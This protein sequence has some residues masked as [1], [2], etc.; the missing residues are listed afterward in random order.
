MAIL[1][2]G[3]TVKF[4]YA[5]WLQGQDEDVLAIASVQ[6]ANQD[7]YKLVK[8]VLDLNDGP[9]IDRIALELS[10]NFPIS[11]VIAHSEYDLL[12]AARLRE[13]LGL[14]G[15]TV[16]GAIAYRDKVVMK[17][18]LERA[19]IAVAHADRL[20]EPL[21]AI[22]FVSKHGY[23]VVLKPTDGAGSHDVVIAKSESEVWDALTMLRPGAS[24]IETYVEGTMYH[25]NG[26][27]AGSNVKFFAPC[28]YINGALDFR[29]GKVFGS[30]T[31]HPASSLARR[32]VKFTGQ[33]IDALPQ[34]DVL[35][36]HAEIFLTP[37]D[38]LVLC[39]IAS[40]TAG[41]L[42][43]ELIER[44]YG[45]NLHRSW[46]KAQAGIDHEM[47]QAEF[48]GVLA[49]SLRV[50]VREQRLADLPLT[51]PF[52]W[53]S[54]VCLTGR[55]GHEHTKASTYTDDVLSAI[56]VGSTDEQLS[57]RITEYVDWLDTHVRWE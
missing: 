10:R 22:S 12:R 51:V 26:L 7:K 3:R 39:E 35:A 25:V 19:G 13:F 14:N 17:R 57:L 34:S 8:R 46:V 37:K 31:L 24:A 43:I 5:G 15:Q 6:L 40:R 29:L 36:F 23:P 52:P 1:C 33:V 38:E 48:Q 45:V 27:I 44:S 32:L 9:L 18:Y 16:E 50:P 55:P 42:T 41:S 30:K 56:I 11:R 2:Y 47:T 28:A 49:A 20:T 54:T 53:V 4:D 21:D